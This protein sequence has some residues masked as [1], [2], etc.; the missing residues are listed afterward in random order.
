MAIQCPELRNHFVKIP[1]EGGINIAFS[2]DNILRRMSDM[3]TPKFLDQRNLSLRLSIPGYEPVGIV[4]DGVTPNV[5]SAL[6]QDSMIS[7]LRISNKKSFEE[8]QVEFYSST[9]ATVVLS[10]EVPLG[11]EF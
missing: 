11:L 9:A 8:L 3:I 2:P 10:V 1:L 6:E 5:V 4:L 7:F